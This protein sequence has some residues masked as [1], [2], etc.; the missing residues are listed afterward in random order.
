MFD[1]ETKID[2]PLISR[3]T[4][5]KESEVVKILQQLENDHIIEL[6]LANSDSEITF[7]KPREDDLTI[8]PYAS[9]IN[10]QINTKKK[11]IGA[12]LHYIENNKTCKQAQ[13]LDYF[14]EKPTAPCGI[15]SV[16]SS[17]KSE[18]SNTANL[19]EAIKE[20]IRNNSLSSRQ[21]ADR[22]AADPA[23]LLLT[24]QEL[25]EANKICITTTNKYIWKSER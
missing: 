15:C 24:L 19:K 11:N 1:Y 2:L 21:I 7:I 6:H 25:L 22:V 18:A 3:K 8:N 5:I 23:S 13:I 12:V 4:K 16:C 20:L 14:G 10:Q 9:I 17:S